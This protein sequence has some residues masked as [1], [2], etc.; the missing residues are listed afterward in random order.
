MAEKNENERQEPTPPM[1]RASEVD[2]Y[3]A[4][5]FLG[6]GGKTD[7]RHILTCF[8]MKL[9]TMEENNEWDDKQFDKLLVAKNILCREAVL[10][11]I[12]ETPD[13]RFDISGNVPFQ[14]PCSKCSGVGEKYRFVRETQDVK[15]MKCDGTGKSSENTAC[16]I[17]ARKTTGG[18][19]PGKVRTYGIIS[20]LREVTSCET[21]RGK[22]YFQPKETD[23][24][25]VDPDTARKLKTHL[26][27]KDK[28]EGTTI[29]DAIHAS[30]IPDQV[31]PN[32]M[33]DPDQD[34]P[35]GEG[36]SQKIKQSPAE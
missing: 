24:P 11:Q 17:C 31:A 2:R 18:P 6:T 28:K 13:H 23:N 27:E 8:E 15:C 3:K 4:H 1:P 21:C 25:V 20:Q 33:L 22:G 12:D 10:N 9:W 35:L 26:V 29:G 16:P 32:P 19:P 36:T 34:K 7:L 30:V 14:N 5:T